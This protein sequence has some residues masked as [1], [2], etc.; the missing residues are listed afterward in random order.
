MEIPTLM[1]AAINQIAFVPGLTDIPELHWIRTRKIIY[2]PKKSPAST[3]SDYRPL[4][5]LE[6]FI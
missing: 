2:I 6:V 3:L 4:S 5:M 1:T